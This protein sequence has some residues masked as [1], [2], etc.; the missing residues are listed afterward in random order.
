MCTTLCAFTNIVKVIRSFEKGIEF[1][2]TRFSL[3]QVGQTLYLV[4]PVKTRQSQFIA[5]KFRREIL[6]WLWKAG[7]MKV[8]GVILSSFFTPSGKS[9]TKK[10]TPHDG[11]Y[12]TWLRPKG[13][14]FS[15][16]CYMKG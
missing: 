12:G 4:L 8:C 10:R 14:P 2:N 15:S 1:T 5:G 9:Y 7:M 16:F 11:I 3:S 13:V 6:E